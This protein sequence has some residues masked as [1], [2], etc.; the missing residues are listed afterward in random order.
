MRRILLL[1][2]AAATLLL[3][4][5]IYSRLLDQKE[6]LKDFDRHVAVL[7]GPGLRLGLLMPVLRTADPDWVMG[8]PPEV[9]RTDDGELRT[10][11]WQRAGGG[12][13]GMREV[14][15]RCLVR[16]GKVVEVRLPEQ[17]F[18]FM[19]R[20]RFLGMLRALGAARVD[21]DQRQV[22]AAVDGQRAP[23]PDRAAL[24]GDLGEPQARE[25]DRLWIYRYVL[26][27]SPEPDEPVRAEVRLLFR[28]DGHAERLE[29]KFANASLGFD[30]EAPAPAPEK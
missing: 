11:M 26:R 30:W 7:D 10:W 14:P 9:E 4:G 23:A 16:D 24:L 8:G 19:P 12:E 15:L 18:A 6:Q 27:S 29:A 21:R 5:C 1:L 13:A 28:P 22:A 25:G 2:S 20:D 3:G 17:V